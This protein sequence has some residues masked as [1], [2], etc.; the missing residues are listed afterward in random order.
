MGRFLRF[1]AKYAAVAKKTLL[2]WGPLGAERL[3]F[4]GTWRE[5]FILSLAGTPV[6]DWA[7]YDFTLRRGDAKKTLGRV[8]IRGSG[9]R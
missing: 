6:G 5:G 2:G 3:V 1:H 4:F 8:G 7:F 9:G